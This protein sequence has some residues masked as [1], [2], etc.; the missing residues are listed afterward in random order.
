M[1][2]FCWI[3]LLLMLPA[4]LQAE[5]LPVQPCSS[6]ALSA[7]FQAMEGPGHRY[8]LAI[9]L[10]NISGETCWVDN[11]PGGTGMAPDPT[12]DGTWIQICY[13]C[14][15]DSKR[16][17]EA[18]LTLRPGESVHQTRSWKT[19]S[20]GV[21]KCASPTEM[22]WDKNGESNSHFWLF[23]RSLLK[24]ICSAVVTTNYAAGKF[25]T[26]T[27]TGPAF[28]SRTPNV[29][30]ANDETAPYS[31]EHV[32]LRVTVEDRGN[33]L[34][35]DEHFCPLLFLRTRDATPSRGAFYRST[36]VD[37]LQ[38][39]VCKAE[40]VGTA[41]RRF[42]VD[43]EANDALIRKNDE[44]KGEYTLDVSSLAE[45]GGR[46]FLV[47]GTEPLRL[48]MV[49]GK[50]I[51][52]NWG[53]AVQGVAVSLTLDK[54]VYSLGSDIPLHIAVEN[55]DSHETIAAMDP[56][57]DPPGV[58]V[59]LQDQA[60]HSIPFGEGAMWMGHGFCHHFPRGLVFPI[61]LMLSQMGI[62]PDHPGVYTVIAVWRPMIG[63]Y[64]GSPGTIEPSDP[65]IQNLTVKSYPV[66]LKVVDPTNREAAK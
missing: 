37:E 23:S 13:Y 42:T 59:E 35:V 3:P 33:V 10:Q 60:G 62:R 6:D 56:Y 4:A 52:R 64:C 36:R 24:P 25:L 46:Y 55:A 2:R 38:G 29:R 65:A 45:T 43:F 19:Y 48:S 26:N 8:T 47:A 28:R 20:G 66:T 32:P 21:T 49:N 30:W 34:I 7:T 58:A 11:Y 27:L 41:G 22:S 51:S 18:R 54:D 17:P 15:Q 12:P 5:P 9:N 57:F 40:A 1:L 63:D 31:R 44:N 61:E 53:P 50:F 14:E 16:P 39:A